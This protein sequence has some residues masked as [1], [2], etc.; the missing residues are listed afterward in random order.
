MAPLWIQGTVLGLVQ[1]VSEFLPVSSSGH[2]ILVPFLT[3]WEHL[4]KAFD[5][6]LHLGTLVAIVAYFQDEVQGMGRVLGGSADARH[7]Q[8]LQWL[9]AATVPAGIVGLILDSYLDRTFGGP[10]SVALFLATFGLLLGWAD[11]VGRK[12]R[13]MDQ[14]RPRD[15]AVVGCAQILALVPG[16][17]RCG[18][19]LTAG[20]LCGLTR[21]EAAR[22]SFL[23]ALPVTLGAFVLK[24]GQLFGGGLSPEMRWAC[25]LGMIVA[26]GSGWL[27]I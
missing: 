5:V 22:F 25:F 12:N 20:L 26:A 17:S 14:L 9:V 6:A 15:V 11:R 8:L 21:S 4:G 7:R 24:S 27:C 3:G 23:M 16:V 2:L 19:T 10:R 18:I 1:G 13:E